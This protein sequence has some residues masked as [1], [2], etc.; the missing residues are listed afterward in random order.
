MYQGNRSQV[1]Q[2][3]QGRGRGTGYRGRGRNS[4]G[5]GRGQ[6]P[7]GPWT[8][9]PYLANNWSPPPPPMPTQ[10]PSPQGNQ[11]WANNWTNTPN[12]NSNNSP[13]TMSQAQQAQQFGIPSTHVAAQQNGQ[14][15]PSSPLP[16]HGPPPGFEA[17]SAFSPTDL[18]QA[19]QQ[20]H[21]NATDQSWYMDSGASSHIS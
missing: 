2:G 18:S 15:V 8:N 19:L 16:A 4:R 9:T 11:R 21:L 3:Y 10:G 20:V 1:S 17:Y 5:R 14:T 13:G 12:W 6:S 7:S